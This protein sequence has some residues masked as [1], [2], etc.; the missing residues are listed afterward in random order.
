MDTDNAFAILEDAVARCQSEDMHTVE[1]FAAL[2]YLAGR[3]AVKWPT[4]QFRQGLDDHH[5]EVRA[6]ILSDS[7]AAI[8]LMLDIQKK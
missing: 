8:K 4:D 1:V 6:K 5:S 2:H 7:L 3:M